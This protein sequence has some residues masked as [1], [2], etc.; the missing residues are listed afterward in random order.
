[1][2]ADAGSVQGVVCGDFVLP[3]VG[4]THELPPLGVVLDMD[5]VFNICGLANVDN[6]FGKIFPS[7]RP[8]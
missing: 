2:R 3:D 5:A 4:D 1:M 8:L 6:L 7:W